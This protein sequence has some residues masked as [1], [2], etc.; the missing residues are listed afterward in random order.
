MNKKRTFVVGI[1]C[2][3]ALAATIN[4]SYKINNI[5]GK[6][7]L[8][9]KEIEVTSPFNSIYLDSNIKVIITKNKNQ[10][11]IIKAESN[12]LPL[13]NTYIAN[14]ALIITNERKIKKSNAVIEVEMNNIHILQAMSGTISNENQ[15][16]KKGHIMILTQNNAQTNLDLKAER[17]Y[18][19]INNMSKAYLSG[20]TGFLKVTA[21]HESELNALEM[22][23]IKASISSNSIKNCDITVSNQ[24][25]AA[26]NGSGDIRYKGSPALAVKVMGTGGL[27]ML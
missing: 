23:A 25:S 9:S 14:N 3:I 5:S 7:P 18:V 27:E 6:G 8:I 20:S 10:K 11:V 13:I 2:F 24:L 1:I 22:T 16:D 19:E 26:I 4:I 12:V 21:D 17:V 15:I